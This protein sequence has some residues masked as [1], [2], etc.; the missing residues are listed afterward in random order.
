M[1]ASLKYIRIKKAITVLKTGGIIAYPTEGVYG[2]GCDPFD[3]ATVHRLLQIKQRN[4]Y[5]GL[6]LIAA[7]WESIKKLVK[8]NIPI[9]K[10]KVAQAS[11]PGP[12]T[13]I[14]PA[15][16]VVPPWIKGQFDTVALR[17]TA[18]PIAHALCK[19]FEGPIVSTSANIS[20]HSS[21]KLL[22]DV[23][24]EFIN[25]VDF[26]L[27]GRVGDLNG[28]TLIRDVLTGETIRKVPYE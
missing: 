9:E 23:R 2:L 27:P 3:P 26:I 15:S 7:D 13:W 6:I 16:D 28:P 22:E 20:A 17:I 18:H 11:W 12:Y 25:K 1:R 4:I 14:F 24:K 5:K 19:A 10:L 8:D 21:L